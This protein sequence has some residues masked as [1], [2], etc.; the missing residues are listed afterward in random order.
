[1][2]AQQVD[3][4]RLFRFIFD[5]IESEKFDVGNVIQGI[6]QKHGWLWPTEALKYRLLVPR[7]RGQVRDLDAKVGVLASDR[8]VVSGPGRLDTINPGKALEVGW[9]LNKLLDGN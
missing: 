3:V 6:E 2:P 7:I 4:Q 5:C 8:V 9:D 1:M